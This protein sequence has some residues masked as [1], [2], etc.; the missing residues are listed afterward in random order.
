[1]AATDPKGPIALKQF[2]ELG[3]EAF[4]DIDVFKAAFSL[5]WVRAMYLEDDVAAGKQIALHGA[6]E[7]IVRETLRLLLEK[8]L[9]IES[10]GLRGEFDGFEYDGTPEEL[11]AL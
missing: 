11:G 4:D 7:G 3:P 9:D 8:G 5:G 10:M 6:N 2:G 1:M